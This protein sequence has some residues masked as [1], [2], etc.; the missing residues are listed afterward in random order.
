M[1]ACEGSPE[2]RENPGLPARGGPATRNG[3]QARTGKLTAQP[4][5][6]THTWQASLAGSGRT[7]G[8]AAAQELLVGTGGAQAQGFLP[9]L[10]GGGMLSQAEMELPDGHV[11][12]RIAGG[13]A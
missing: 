1:N 11:P 13:D 10:C 2:A 8:E 7:F 9:G 6:V 3:A 4:T 12:A 5:A